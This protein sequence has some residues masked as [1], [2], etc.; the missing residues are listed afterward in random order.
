MGGVVIT[1]DYTEVPKHPV[2]SFIIKYRIL[3]TKEE[4][5]YVHDIR[6]LEN[7]RDKRRVEFPNLRKGL[8]YTF[9][10]QARNLNGF[11]LESEVQII[12]VPAT[13]EIHFFK[14][15]SQRRNSSLKKNKPS[16]HLVGAE[17]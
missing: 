13:C 3:E 16:S 2:T 17:L 1:W 11:S 6:N 15:F 12:A 7:V 4:F 14:N 10:V 5:E 9:R 8:Q